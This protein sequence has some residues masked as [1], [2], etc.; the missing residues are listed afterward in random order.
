MPGLEDEVDSAR[1]NN[2]DQGPFRQKIDCLYREEKMM[3]PPSGMI[4]LDEDKGTDCQDAISHEKESCDQENRQ[5]DLSFPHT[6]H[7]I[8]KNV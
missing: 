5:C 2:L 8:A 4:E 1:V 6:Y 7:V 3:M